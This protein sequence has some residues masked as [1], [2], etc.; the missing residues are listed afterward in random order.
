MTD[1]EDFQSREELGWTEIPDVVVGEVEG[2]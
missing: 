2:F 1:I